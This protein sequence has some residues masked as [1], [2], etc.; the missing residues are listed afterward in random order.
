R[1]RPADGQVTGFWIEFRAAVWTAVARKLTRQESGSRRSRW[2]LLRRQ[3]GL[4]PSRPS[5]GGHTNV[6]VPGARSVRRRPRFGR[7]AAAAAEGAT[8]GRT[9]QH[10]PGGPQS[11]RV[12]TGSRAIGRTGRGTEFGSVYALPGAAGSR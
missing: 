4:G 3:V 8:R 9:S 6:E 1:K 12:E 7:R 11:G 5:G 10:R 2:R